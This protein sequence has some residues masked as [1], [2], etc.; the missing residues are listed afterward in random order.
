MYEVLP[1]IAHNPE[2]VVW[3]DFASQIYETLKNSC[4]KNTLKKY[5]S[6][7]R[8]IKMSRSTSQIES[9]KKYKTF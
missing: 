8:H 1:I 9:A 7:G 2:Y 6:C 5:Y 4:D 3:L